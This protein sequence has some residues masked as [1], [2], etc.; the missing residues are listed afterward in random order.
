MSLMSSALLAGILG[1][2]HARS[3]AVHADYGFADYVRDFGR[4]YSGNELEVRRTIVEDNFRRIKEHNASPRR[5]WEASINKFVDRSLVEFQQLMGY[6][7]VQARQRLEPGVLGTP[8]SMAPNATLPQWVDWRQKGAISEVKDQGSCGGCWGFSAAEAIESH[9]ALHGGP[10]LRLAPEEFIACTPNLE[11]CGGKGGCSGG[12][13][14]Q[15]FNFSMQ[16]GIVEESSY[17]FRRGPRRHK[18]DFTKLSAP[19]VQVTGFVRLPSNDAQALMTALAQQGPL[20][21]LVAATPWQLYDKGIFDGELG[22]GCGLDINHAVQLVGYGSEDGIDYWLVRNSWGAGWGEGGYIRLLRQPG[23]ES[24]GLDPAP[25]DGLCG[26]SGWVVVVV[27]VVDV[28]VVVVVAVVVVVVDVVVVVAVVVVAAADAAT[29][30]YVAVSCKVLLLLL[31]LLL[32][33]LQLLLLELLLQ[34][35]PADVLAAA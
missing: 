29:A 22:M 4:Q 1:C 24:C 2:A 21:I 3:Q 26:K 6:D 28:V 12:T 23:H 33:L 34:L 17:P 13:L 18:C 27:V 11:H 30:V 14:E 20:S 35:L 5:L 32:L 7:K 31:M 10:L 25:K 16:H 15:A 8:Y 19:R 9:L